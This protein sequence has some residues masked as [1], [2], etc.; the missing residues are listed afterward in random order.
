MN[1]KICLSLWVEK[2]KLAKHSSQGAVGA[3]ILRR[4]VM[5]RTIMVFLRSPPE[6]GIAVVDSTMSVLLAFGLVMKKRIGAPTA[7]TWKTAIYARDLMMMT[8]RTM[9]FL[10]VA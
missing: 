10:S 8:T 9:Q 4:V 3:T 2:I 7:C 1:G 5:E 6:L